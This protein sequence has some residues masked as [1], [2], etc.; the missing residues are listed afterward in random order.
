MD[1]NAVVVVIDRLGAG[2]LGPYGNTWIETPALDRLASQAVLWETCLADHPTVAGYY[3]ALTWL[4]HARCPDCPD[5]E[6]TWMERATAR[7]VHTVLLTDE[8]QL[9]SLRWANGFRERHTIPSEPSPHPATSIENTAMA[10]VFAA[11]SECLEEMRTPF[12]LWLHV[13]GMAGP[14]DAPLEYR[15]SFADEEDPLPPDGVDPPDCRLSADADPDVILGFSQAYAGQVLLAD[16]CLA[17]LLHAWEATPWKTDSLFVLTSPR[18]Y[19]LAERGALGSS[20]DTLHEEVLHV[21][22]LI[23]HPD[24]GWATMRRQALVQPADL[25]HTLEEWFQL[26]GRDRLPGTLNLLASRSA[27]AQSAAPGRGALVSILGDERSLRTPAWFFRTAPGTPPALY[28]KPDDRWEVNEVADRCAPVVEAATQ[29]LLAAEQWLER[30][31]AGHP[32][33]LPTILWQPWE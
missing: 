14:W 20:G 24:P 2:Y 7:G 22:L 25:G 16:A 9:A 33:D 1:R 18:G 32:P 3:R 26:N 30:N 10:Q 5:S 23:R 15:R 29:T 12:L 13:R 4:R 28:A 17:P 21:P 27:A 6:P 31:C 8:P 19:P 11:A